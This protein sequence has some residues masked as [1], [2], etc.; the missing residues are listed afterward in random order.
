VR[1]EKEHVGDNAG[2]GRQEGQLE[3]HPDA[4]RNRQEKEIGG[5]EHQKKKRAR[6]SR[7]VGGA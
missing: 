1:P 5:G 2:E 6:G 4:G 3:I 7:F